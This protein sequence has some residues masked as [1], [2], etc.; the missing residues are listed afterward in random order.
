[1]DLDLPS[2]DAILSLSLTDSEDGSINLVTITMLME[3]QMHL[4]LIPNIQIHI[5]LDLKEDIQIILKMNFK[6][7]SENQKFM[8]VMKKSKKYTILTSQRYKQILLFSNHIH[9]TNHSE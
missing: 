7:N 2:K 1:M 3:M 4:L 9:L 8:K 5:N 6:R